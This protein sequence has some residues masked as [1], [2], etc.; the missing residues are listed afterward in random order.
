MFYD[1]HGAALLAILRPGTRLRLP[2]G[3]ASNR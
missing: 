1:S 2:L 3:R